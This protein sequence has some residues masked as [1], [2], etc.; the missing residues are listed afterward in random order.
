MM[1]TISTICTALQEYQGIRDRICNSD[2]RIAVNSDL[3]RVQRLVH[4]AQ[5]R[6]DHRNDIDIELL[7]LSAER[8]LWKV[9]KTCS[10]F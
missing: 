4:Q 9:A 8:C 5:D 6:D 3:E 10:M 2:L 1:R 7:L